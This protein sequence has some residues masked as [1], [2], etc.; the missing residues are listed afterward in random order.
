MGSL[1]VLQGTVRTRLAG[2]NGRSQQRTLAQEGHCCHT[3]GQAART[4][5][6][7]HYTDRHFILAFFLWQ[8]CCD[9]KYLDN[10]CSLHFHRHLW[11]GRDAS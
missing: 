6:M 5:H 10:L 11:L 3:L 7:A 2:L 8:T 4:T 9:V 1:E